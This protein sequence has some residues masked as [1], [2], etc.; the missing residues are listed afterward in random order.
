MRSTSPIRFLPPLLLAGG[1]VSCIGSSCT[2]AL[3]AD[4]RFTIRVTVQG[5]TLEGAPLHQSEDRTSLLGRDGRLWLFESR[6][7][8]S[9]ARISNDFR[10]YSPAELRARLLR[11]FGTGYQVTGTVHYL[12]VHR[13]RLPSEWPQRFEDLYRGF[14][15]YCTARGLTPRAPEFPLVAIIYGSPAEFH[16][17]AEQE[18]VRLGPGMIGYYSS[19]SNRVV[20]YEQPASNGD[21]WKRNAATIVHEAT[22]Q[23]AFNTGL[24][25]RCSPAPRWIVEGLA[26][27]FECPAVWDAQP[28]RPVRERVNAGQLAAFRDYVQSRRRT[29]T[30]MRLVTEDDSFR[31]DPA[32]AYSEAWALTFYLAETSPRS[33]QQYLTKTSAPPSSAPES[34]RRVTDFFA[35]FGSDPAMLEARLLRFIADLK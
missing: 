10:A 29:G 22:H 32:A 8:T 12:V 7:A 1:L 35:A 19:Q 16:Q 3:S 4:N 15:R 24:H 27:M 14:V 20:M 25:S 6:S 2:V 11:E 30:L 26:T 21:H 17:H 23:A 9:F 5:E 28:N 31:D 34:Q 13:E 18:A 33:L